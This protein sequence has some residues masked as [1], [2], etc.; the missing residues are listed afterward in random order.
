[1]FTPKDYFIGIKS[2]DYYFGVNENLTF[3]LVT[4]DP[5]DKIIKDSKPKQN[6]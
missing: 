2:T 1:M 5:N 4:V 3:N 6:L